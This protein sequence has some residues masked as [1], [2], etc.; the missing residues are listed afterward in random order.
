MERNLE[1][2]R[3]RGERKQ[4]PIQ[5][6][7]EAVRKRD[8]KRTSNLIGEHGM[9]SS[10]PWSYLWHENET[11]HDRGGDDDGSCYEREDE[12]DVASAVEDISDWYGDDT[13]KKYRV[14]G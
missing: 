12:V 10:G 3:D 8:I 6:E 13:R 4:R 14:D 1:W 11:E 2:W 7:K 5:I 9:P